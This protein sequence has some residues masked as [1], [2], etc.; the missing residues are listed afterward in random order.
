MGFLPSPKGVGEQMLRPSKKLLLAA[1]VLLLLSFP[2]S[3]S[4]KPDFRKSI[5]NFGDMHPD[6]TLHNFCSAWAVADDGDELRTYWVTAAHC[7]IE[8]DDNGLPTTADYRIGGE[9]AY[10]LKLDDKVDLAILEGPTAPGLRIAYSEPKMRQKVFAFT[11]FLPD[12]FYSEGVAS[13]QDSRGYNWFNLT[14]GPGSSGSA[15][16]S[17]DADLVVGIVQFGPCPY[18]CSAVGGISVKTLR[19][20]VYGE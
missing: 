6:G 5:A 2:S 15:V 14:A 8:R 3:P 11:Y 9:K 17:L 19:A 10:L 18:P 13:T 12:G 4:A 7:I 16:L 1:T 20:F